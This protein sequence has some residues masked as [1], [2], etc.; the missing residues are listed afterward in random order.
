MSNHYNEADMED[1]RI[2]SEHWR[3]ASGNPAGGITQGVG[4]LISWQHGPLGRGITRR[5]RNGAFVEDVIAAVVD[6][7]EEYQASSFKCSCNQVA[8]D[9]L[10]RALGS[11]EARTADREERGVEGTHKQ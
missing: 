9:H 6:R 3:D 4:L 11:L 8:I 10:N 7:L 1:N 2:T 5:G